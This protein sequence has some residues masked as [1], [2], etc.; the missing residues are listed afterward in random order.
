MNT[1]PPRMPRQS[2]QAH[3]GPSL[4][5]WTAMARGRGP[6]EP[7]GMVATAGRKPVAGTSMID[8]GAM[9]GVWPGALGGR[10]APAVVVAAAGA[11]IDVLD[12]DG[13]GVGGAARSQSARSAS[14]AAMAR[15]AA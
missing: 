7:T 11:V 6:E 13:A 9:S 1:P 14:V 2:G 8:S 15:G 10:G 3:W 4:S 5:P 12:A